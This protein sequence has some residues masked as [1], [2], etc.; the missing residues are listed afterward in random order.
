MTHQLAFQIILAFYF[1]IIDATLTLQFYIFSRSNGQPTPITLPD[2]EEYERELYNSLAHAAFE[3]GRRRTKSADI[4]R[5]ALSWEGIGRYS[6][7]TDSHHRFQQSRQPS[8]N[9]SPKRFRSQ[10]RGRSNKKTL[11]SILFLV[12][13]VGSGGATPVSYVRNI[14]NGHQNCNAIRIIGRIFSWSCV[15][16][17]L[18]SR[19]PQIYKNVR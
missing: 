15:T 11:A 13:S 19:M 14:D 7:S 1:V 16:F 10:S 8:R 2:E 18:A 5:M 3:R 17:Y 9:T 4:N 12:L 6:M